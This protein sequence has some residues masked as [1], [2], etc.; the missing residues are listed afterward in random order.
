[1]HLKYLT[2]D[3]DACGYPTN[4]PPDKCFELSVS[5]N[6]LSGMAQSSFP[7]HICHLKL[8]GQLCHT[9]QSLPL[10]TD[11]AACVPRDAGRSRQRGQRQSAG[12]CTAGTGSALAAGHP[13]E[14]G[15]CG[16]QCQEL[17]QGQGQA[18]LQSLMSAHGTGTLQVLTVSQVCFCVLFETRQHLLIKPLPM[19]NF[20][21][22]RVWSGSHLCYS[23]QTVNSS[24]N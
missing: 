12:G 21:R 13:T 11:P 7:K 8:G 23:L 20:P 9:G 4:H 17:C 5:R 10:C 16:L 2:Y 18:A 15:S 1:M 22:S 19:G 6:Q 3:T 14:A 24:P